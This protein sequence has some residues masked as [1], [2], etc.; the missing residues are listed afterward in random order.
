MNELEGIDISI[1]VNNVGIGKIGKFNEFST[2]DVK[3][4]FVVNVFP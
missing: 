4:L 2:K 3:D 1:W